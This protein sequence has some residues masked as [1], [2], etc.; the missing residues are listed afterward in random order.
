MNDPLSDYMRPHL[1]SGHLMLGGFA[2]VVDPRVPKET[3]GTEIVPRGR[4]V[5]RLLRW[6]PRRWRPRWYRI[7]DAIKQEQFL[8]AA[9][10]LFCTPAGLEQLRKIAP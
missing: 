6:I 5:R 4:L 9:G 2:V 1:A 8:F 7:G 3:V 10:K